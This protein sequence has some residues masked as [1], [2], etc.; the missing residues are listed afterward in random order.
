MYTAIIFFQYLVAFHFI[1]SDLLRGGCFMNYIRVN[2]T[3][4]IVWLR[5]V[6]SIL[7]LPQGIEDFPL[8]YF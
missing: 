8:S 4:L 3:F 5:I 6:L 1:N 7:W 2:Q